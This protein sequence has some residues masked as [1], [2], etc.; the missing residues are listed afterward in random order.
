MI[1]GARYVSVPELQSFHGDFLGDRRGAATALVRL[2]ESILKIIRLVDL[3]C[4]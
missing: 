2:R 4:C 3:S 1:C